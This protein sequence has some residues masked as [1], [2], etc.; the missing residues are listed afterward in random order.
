MPEPEERDD[1]TIVLKFGGGQHSSESEEEINNREAA[2]AENISLD[3]E[4]RNLRNRKPIDLIGTVPNGAEIR[5]FGNLIETDGTIT[6]LVQAGNTVFKF[7]ENIGFINKGTVNANMRMRGHLHHYWSLDDIVILTDLNLTDVVM[8]WDGGTLSDMTHNLTGD[9]KAKYCYVEDERARYGH[10]SSNSVI[11]EHMIVTSKLSDHDNLSTSD[12]PTSALGADDPYFLLTPDLRAVNGIA[13]SFGV[14]G[15]SSEFGSIYKITG[16][17]TS[18]T[19]IDKMYPR[20]FAS[21]DEAM[22]YV[23]NDVVYG[24]VGRIE[25]LAATEVFGDVQTDDLSL[26][27][28]DEIT[29][30]KDWTIVFNPRTNKIVFHPAGKQFM[31]E[32]SKPMAGSGLSPWTKITT[33]HSF[34]MKQTA[35]MMMVDPDDGLEYIFMG[36]AS[37]NVYRLEGRGTK[38]DAGS[39]DIK[40]RWKSKLFRLP[41]N[42]IGRDFQG[43]ISYRSGTD[44]T[45]T[46][47]FLYAG[48]IPSDEPTTVELKGTPG[49][50]FWGATDI[51]WGETDLFWGVP[52]QGR[53][54]R[55]QLDFSGNSEEF[56]IE[57]T[58]EGTG[59][60]EIN[61]IGIRFGAS[62][63]SP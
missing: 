43:Y 3:L 4:D 55:E 10:V 56:Q 62:G 30:L 19:S 51:F 54:K 59:D 8:E 60:V 38:G 31:W 58:Y 26:D 63:T 13:S 2:I 49:T 25:S 15:I 40:L 36:D 32:Y 14:L 61:E 52:F 1:G 47:K 34:R 35:M 9:F 6:M 57:I 42:V 44:E 24:R 7:S 22:I 27:I 46:I 41:P 21:G 16:Q 48:S 29:D 5:G 23:G 39:A 37:G 50:N 20:S 45:V 18:D 11:T 12:K 53:F 17:D 28:K 33:S